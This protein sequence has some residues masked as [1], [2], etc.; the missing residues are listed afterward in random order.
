MARKE[1]K[2]FPILTRPED[3]EFLTGEYKGKDFKV[4]ARKFLEGAAGFIDAPTADDMA[5]FSQGYYG[6]LSAVYFGGVGTDSEILIT[7]VDVYQDVIMTV[8]SLGVADERTT[9]MKTAVASGHTGTGANGSPIVF[10][11]EGLK[12]SSS[13]NLRAS[14]TFTPDEDGGRLDSRVVFNR[15]SAASPSG[16]FSIDAAG[17]AMESGADEEYPNLV[18]V[19]FFVG[20]T[21]NTNGVGDAGKIRFQVKS[22]VPGTLTMN[23]LALFIQL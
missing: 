20:D 4:T 1:S 17:L 14:M 8:H 11:L 7:E 12:K 21:I 15:H 5:A 9:G 10:D 16:D 23:E 19:Q 13:G 6:L 22:D 18:N 3:L 2:N